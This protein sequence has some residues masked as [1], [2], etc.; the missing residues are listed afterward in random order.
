MI[1]ELNHKRHEE[2]EEEAKEGQRKKVLNVR[3][4]NAFGIG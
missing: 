4:T 2:H 3:K 1:K